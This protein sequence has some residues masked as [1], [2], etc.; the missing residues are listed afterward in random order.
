MIPWRQSPAPTLASYVR[1]CPRS[2]KTT[3]NT[4]NSNSIRHAGQPRS[5]TNRL[6]AYR[7]DELLRIE[8]HDSSGDLPHQRPTHDLDESGRGLHLVG[9]LAHDHASYR[10]PP[11]KVVWFTL[12]V[13][14]RTQG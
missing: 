6:L 10:T 2:Q 8:V 14:S 3:S 7:E 1:Q 11:G 12:E 5:A 13:W 9:L 4:R